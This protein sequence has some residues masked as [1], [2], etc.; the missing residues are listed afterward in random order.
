MIWKIIIVALVW[1]TIDRPA[2]SEVLISPQ[3]QI[4]P[5]NVIK[6]Q[7]QA[8]QQNDNPINDAGIVQTWAF[9]HPSNRL[10]TGPIER[11]TLMMKSENYKNILYHRNHKIEPVFKTNIRSQ[12]AVTITTLDDK[13]MTFK[14]ELEKVQSGQFS[15]SWMTTS[16]S[17]PLPFGDA[18]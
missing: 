4:D 6:I 3:P 5:K 1:F 18:L 12:F 17:P 13:K 2:T 16:V 14:W 7:L 15:G 11:F 10:M 8:L 9:A